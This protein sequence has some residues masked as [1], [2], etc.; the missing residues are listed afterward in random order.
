MSN[1]KSVKSIKS[2]SSITNNSSELMIKFKDH[3]E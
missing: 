3:I 2:N 1:S